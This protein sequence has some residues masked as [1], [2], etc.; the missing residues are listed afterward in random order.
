MAI[1]LDLHNGLLRINDAFYSLSFSPTL[2]DD[3]IDCDTIRHLIN[4]SL[5]SQVLTEDLRSVL[6]ALKYTHPQYLDTTYLVHF[7][8][9]MSLELCGLC[10]AKDS[11]LVF[12]RL[13][14]LV[15]LEDIE[16]LPSFKCY[17]FNARDIRKAS[18]Q[19]AQRSINERICHAE[20]SEVEEFHLT[21]VD[22]LAT[23]DSTQDLRCFANVTLVEEPVSNGVDLDANDSVPRLLPAKQELI[24]QL[25][26]KLHE[27]EI[28]TDQLLANAREM[29]G[30]P[31]SVSLAE[32][33]ITYDF[34]QE[35][36]QHP[37]E[38][39]DFLEPQEEISE[40]D[41]ETDQR[42]WCPRLSGQ[43]S[44]CWNSEVFRKI[45]PVL[46]VCVVLGSIYFLTRWVYDRGKYSTDVRQS[47]LPV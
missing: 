1:T 11:G 39:L 13:L 8:L 40:R 9:R 45:S 42:E 3:L 10:T 33:A 24:G 31:S 15:P 23:A 29:R 7:C 30:A 6:P 47:E 21:S 41:N 20:V 37:L 12:K 22:D 14:E 44:A 38:S 19:I 5:H 4:M 34:T 32:E 17:R 18:N 28:R 27:M 36:S 35:D 2:N 26:D 16:E 46:V 25:V 43:I